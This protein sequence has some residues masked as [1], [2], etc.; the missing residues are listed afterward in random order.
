MAQKKTCEFTHTHAKKAERGASMCISVKPQWFPTSMQGDTRAISGRELSSSWL[1]T[2]SISQA[3]E[4]MNGPW[5]S[6][7]NQAI[8]SVAFLFLEVMSKEP[9]GVGTSATAQSLSST[10]TLNVVS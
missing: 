7:S 9:G 1:T 8:T 4:T 2:K 6:I 5:T 10:A 3:V